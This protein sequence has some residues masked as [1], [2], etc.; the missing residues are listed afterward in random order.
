MRRRLFIAMGLS[1]GGLLTL[2]VVAPVVAQQKDEKSAS[3]VRVEGNVHMIDIKTKTV[4]VRLTGK[5]DRREVVYSDTTAFTFR[6]KPS[7]L[8]EV[9]EGRRVICVGKLNDKNQLVAKQIEVRDEK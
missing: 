2:L 3:E 8:E 5:P 6:N 1:V 4:T 7:K 9:K